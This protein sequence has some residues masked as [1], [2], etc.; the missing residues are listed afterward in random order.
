[1]SYTMRSPSA[2][3][4]SVQ[5][6]WREPTKDQ[7]Y[8]FI[9]AWLGWTLDAFDF[10]VFLFLLGADRPG[11]SRRPD[12][13]RAGRL[14][15]HVDAVRRC[16]RGRLDGRPDGPASAA[17]DLHP[18]VLDLQLHRRVL[19]DLPVPVGVPHAAG[20]R[21]GRGMA[22][23][24]RAGGRKLAGAL[25][26]P[27]VERAARLLGLGLSDRRRAVCHGVRSDRLARH[28][29]DGRAAGFGGGVDPG[30]RQGTP[31][32]ARKP[33]AAEGEQ[34]RNP[35]ADRRPVP[36]GRANEHAV[37]QLVADQRVHRLLLDLRPVRDL[38]DAGAAF[39]G[40]RGWLAAGILQWTDFPVQFRLG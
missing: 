20:Y 34:R 5:P 25:T 1:M 12:T 16:H 9:A 37:D 29:V 26:R 19:A 18:V 10:T 7:W 32:L 40:V 15:D 31:G 33:E 4:S 24:R 13:C 3:P 2:G 27:D 35:S 36:Q 17:D 22:R 11:I 30:L 28:A 23:R 21:H 6:W 39:V 14:D 8:A 38:P